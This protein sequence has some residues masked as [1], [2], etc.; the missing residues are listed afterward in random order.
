MHIIIS[1]TSLDAQIY[2]FSAL[3]FADWFHIIY[4]Y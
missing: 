2:V 4:M 3:C 1:K